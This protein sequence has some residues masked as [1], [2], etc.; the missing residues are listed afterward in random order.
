MKE[1]KNG[2]DVTITHNLFR[3]IEEYT[4]E[5]AR[6]LN[7]NLSL[8]NLSVTDTHTVHNALCAC[9]FNGILSRNGDKNPHHKRMYLGLHI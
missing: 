5:C 8:R 6:T 2:R 1:E 7:V 9:K 3:I 4:N